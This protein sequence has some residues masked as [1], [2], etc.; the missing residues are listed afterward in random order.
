[1]MKFLYGLVLSAATLPLSAATGFAV[2][3]NPVS[4]NVDHCTDDYMTAIWSGLED[5]AV[6]VSDVYAGTIVYIKFYS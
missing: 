2:F 3:I 4:P 6:N 5:A 1:M